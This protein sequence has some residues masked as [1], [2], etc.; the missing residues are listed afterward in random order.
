MITT[1]V[2]IQPKCCHLEH[3]LVPFETGWGRMQNDSDLEFQWTGKP[4]SKWGKRGQL[5]ISPPLSQ[6]QEEPCGKKLNIV[7]VSEKRPQDKSLH[8]RN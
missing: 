4:F 3:N 8:F 5:E 2:E 6:T 1:I 7:L